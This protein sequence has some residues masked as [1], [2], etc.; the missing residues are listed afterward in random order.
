M[1]LSKKIGIRNWKI[2]QSYKTV[3]DRVGDSGAAARELVQSILGRQKTVAISLPNKCNEHALA[4][5]T[6]YTDT[7]VKTPK[8]TFGG[9]G[10]RS[11]VAK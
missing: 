2:C 7:S 6:T 4:G 9:W 10:H 1:D 3:F 11:L 8:V 5:I